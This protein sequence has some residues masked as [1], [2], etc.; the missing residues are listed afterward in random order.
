MAS[1]QIPQFLDSGDKILGPLNLRQFGYVLGGFLIGVFTYTVTLSIFP[2]LGWLVFTPLVPIAAFTLYFAMGKFNGRDA[3]TYVIKY[4]LNLFKPKV[5]VYSREPY[6]EDLNQ[7]LAKWTPQ[8]IEARWNKQITKE[9]KDSQDEYSQF[10]QID[11]EEKAQKIRELGKSIDQ[12]LVNTLSEIKRSQL[13]IESKEA[14][15][16]SVQPNLINN[17][18]QINLY[19]GQPMIPNQPYQSQTAKVEDTNYLK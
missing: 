6:V 10:R 9:T 18:P 16:K 14:M 3:E 15:L 13:K 5:M 11:P 7:E 17:Q 19:Q 4:L 12:G 2:G 8:N 1:Y